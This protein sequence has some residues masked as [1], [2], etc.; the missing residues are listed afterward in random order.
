MAS[1]ASSLPKQWSLSAVPADGI[2]RVVWMTGSHVVASSWDGSVTLFDAVG[3]ARVSSVTRRG[4]VLD[5]SPLSS[6]SVVCGGLD[7]AVSAHD[8][9]TGATTVLGSHTA[10]VRC[11]EHA[12]THGCILSGSWDKT[13]RVWDARLGS[14]A[15]AARVGAAALPERCFAMTTA[16]S[17][18]VI[19]ATAD[20][21]VLFYDL[22]KLAGSSDAQPASIRE[23]SLRHQ[24]RVLRAFPDA[25]G[26]AT[27][28]IEGRVS[29]DF[30]DESNEGKFAFKVRAVLRGKRSARADCVELT[31][32]PC[33]SRAQCHRQKL[34]TGDEKVFPVNAIA[35]HPCGTFA[36]GGSDGTVCMWDGNVKKRIVQFPEYG[37]PIT[38]LDFSPDGSLLAV[39]SSYDWTQGDPA[40]LPTKP[41]ADNIFIR[42]VAPA[43]VSPKK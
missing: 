17:D 15:S 21:K 42:A 27:G 10:A 16:G 8:F 31:P 19:V 28:C 14:G 11:V 13:L 25:T 12:P 33:P 35:F 39:A 38:S 6:T 18:T 2:S 9:A 22:R 30:V 1:S 29:L 32:K 40:N 20:Q 36:T 43:E 7:M 5:V 24:T 26:F 3:N 34:A 4:A 37:A 23:S 41:A